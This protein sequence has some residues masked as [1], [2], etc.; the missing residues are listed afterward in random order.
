MPLILLLMLV[1]LVA[2]AKTYF[3]EQS[4]AVG[5]KQNRQANKADRLA[6]RAVSPTRFVLCLTLAPLFV[7]VDVLQTNVSLAINFS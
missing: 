5:T 3:D 2:Q 6:D 4:L 7:E 1:M